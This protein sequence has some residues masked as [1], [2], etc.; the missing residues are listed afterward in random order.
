MKP[1]SQNK[2]DW[3]NEE[4]MHD[5]MN[6]SPYGALCQP[7]IIQAIEEYCKIIIAEKDEI[8]KAAE[9][10]RKENR[11]KGKISIV[12]QEAWVG[13][14]EDIHARIQEKYHTKTN[15]DG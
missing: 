11:K 10:K 3:S 9:K 7:F 15:T 14:A 1:K 12:N 8:L 13:I 4:F 2:A 5:I 6:Y